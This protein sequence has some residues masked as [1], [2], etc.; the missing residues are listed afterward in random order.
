[1]F[2]S[3][4]PNSRWDRL[5]PLDMEGAYM[6]YNENRCLL[7]LQKSSSV[8]AECICMLR[9]KAQEGDN[10]VDFVNAFLTTNIICG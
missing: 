5:Q 7:S 9:N 1:M 3:L 4:P 2:S 8:L 6:Q 10:N